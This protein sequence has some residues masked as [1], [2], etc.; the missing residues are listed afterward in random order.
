MKHSIEALQIYLFILRFLIQE[1]LR[2]I[3]LKYIIK[4]VN[5][6]NPETIFHLRIEIR[7]NN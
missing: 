1:N 4:I 2:F 6:D 7:R 5:I 3:T